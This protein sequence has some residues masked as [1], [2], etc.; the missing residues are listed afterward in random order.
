MGKRKLFLLNE[1]AVGYTVF[2]VSEAEE[3][4]VKECDKTFAEF[5]RFSKTCQWVGIL[6]FSSQ[7]QALEEMQSVAQATCSDSLANWLKTTLPSVKEGKKAKFEIGVADPLFGSSITKKSSLPCRV[8]DLVRA[9]LRALRRHFA[10]FVEK[11]TGFEAADLGKASVG[12]GHE[13]S[14]AKVEFD[15]KADDTHIVHAISLLEDLNKTLNGMCQRVKEWYG[16][17]FPELDNVLDDQVTYCKVVNII[18]NRLEM[19]CCK[20]RSTR[21]FAPR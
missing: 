21:G 10:H 6:P 14:R 12:L 13:Y 4:A 15:K 3:I 8:D 5:D 11:N 1:S 2:K 9:M 18:G 19:E 20:G 16:L 7:E 17:H